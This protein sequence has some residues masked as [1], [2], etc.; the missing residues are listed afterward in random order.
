MR[1]SY[2][3]FGGCMP[4]TRRALL[5]TGGAA[6]FVLP[7]LAVARGSAPNYVAARAGR[8]FLLHVWATWCPYCQKSLTSIQ[9]GLKHARGAQV[10]GLVTDEDEAAAK[11]FLAAHPLPWDNHLV[12]ETSLLSIQN[13]GYTGSV[14][15]GAIVSAQGNVTMRWTGLLPDGQLEEMLTG[16]VTLAEKT[17]TPTARS[18]SSTGGSTILEFD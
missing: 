16:L 6:T 7:R 4:I 2:P 10:L 12:D 18:K 5:L 15:V 13:L 3:W 14:P 1:A 8:P 11:V 9:A 17:T